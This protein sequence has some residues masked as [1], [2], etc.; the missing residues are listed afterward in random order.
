MFG[1]SLLT[2]SLTKYLVGAA[3][4]ALVVLGAWWYVTYTNGRIE[5]L[6]RE[7]TQLEIALDQY[8]KAIEDLRANY[9]KQREV[10]D[11]LHK[12]MEEAGIPEDKIKDFFNE[13]DLSGMSEEELQKK[14]NE[15]QVDIDRCFEVLSGAAPLPGEKNSVCPHLFES[16]R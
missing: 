2:S 13:N 11:E 14:I 15:Q 12:K 16:Q 4:I 6:V 10:I 1:L 9:E 3:G 5:S 8:K 7:K